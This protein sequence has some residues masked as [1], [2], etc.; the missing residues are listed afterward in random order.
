MQHQSP[1]TTQIPTRNFEQAFDRVNDLI[2]GPILIW[3][4]RFLSP[5][6]LCRRKLPHIPLLKSCFGPHN[7]KKSKLSAVLR[8]CLL[9]CPNAAALSPQC[10]SIG[11]SA[12]FLPFRMLRHC[13]LNAAASKLLTLSQKSQKSNFLLSVQNTSFCF[14][15]SSNVS[16]LLKFTKIFKNW[17]LPWHFL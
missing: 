7:A 8:H 17:L 16:K 3:N 6:Q 10:C 14:F 4:W 9:W 15:S 5:L 13:V 2:F 11:Y 12:N 1:S